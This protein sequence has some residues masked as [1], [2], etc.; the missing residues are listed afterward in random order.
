MDRR[1]FNKLTGLAA[2]GAFSRS[3]DLEGDRSARV[4]DVEPDSEKR[5]MFADKTDSQDW[6]SG[7]GSPVHDS[8][9]LYPIGS[10][11][12]VIENDHLYLAFDQHTGA[13]I[14]FVKKTSGWRWQ[15]APQLGESFTLFA[16]THDRQYC[17]VLGV[18]NVLSSFKKSNDGKSL[19]L[20]W[21][22]LESEYE[23]RLDITLR[24]TV[25]LRGDTVEFDMTIVNHSPEVISSVS[26][27]ILG[28]VAEPPAVMKLSTPNYG[29]MSVSPLWNPF[30]QNAGYFGTNYPTRILDGRFILISTG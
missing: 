30:A 3:P 11:S 23:G 1:T 2:M 21:F 16:P 28:S 17:P 26:W 27:P 15:T 8:D 25:S 7:Q 4:R 5:S 24:G 9:R 10:R 12:I 14:K 6:K 22:D 13:L 18:R 29:S 20:V 19:K